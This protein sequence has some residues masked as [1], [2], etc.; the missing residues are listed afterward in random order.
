MDVATVIII[1]FVIIRFRERL[2]DVAHRVCVFMYVYEYVY[3]Y[4]YVYL[5]LSHVNVSLSFS[6]PFLFSPKTERAQATRCFRIR[7]IKRE[8]GDTSRV[9]TRRKGSFGE[10]AAYNFV[11]ENNN[12]GR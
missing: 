9:F 3:M 7:E 1:L 11:R 4:A 2:G 10:M 8:K 6:P 12:K 5:C